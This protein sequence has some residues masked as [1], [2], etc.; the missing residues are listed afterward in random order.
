MAA[1]KPR[2]VEKEAELFGTGVT[3]ADVE[4]S[5]RKKRGGILP[6]IAGG[7]LLLGGAA[8]GGKMVL[9]HSAGNPDAGV[10]PVYGPAVAGETE[11]THSYMKGTAEVD[12]D[13]FTVPDDVDPSYGKEIK[14][15]FLK[16]IECRNNND[17]GSMKE[18]ID[19]DM[20]GIE[21][22]LNRMKMNGSM[23][24]DAKPEDLLE[25]MVKAHLSNGDPSRIIK[26]YKILDIEQQESTKLYKIIF[27][28]QDG[29]GQMR[30]G[31]ILFYT[32]SGTPRAATHIG[33]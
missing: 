27:M 19:Y 6:W 16:Y 17:V 26:K 23:D 30:T 9:D 8:V 4:R 14:Q 11:T 12:E 20:D 25:I 32:S 13:G 3:K 2:I 33:L 22:E 31:N 10:T 24:A 7:A 21:F 15:A 29:N 28:Y 5:G 18:V 1:T